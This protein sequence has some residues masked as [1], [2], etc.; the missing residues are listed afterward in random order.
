MNLDLIS[1]GLHSVAAVLWT[2]Y[3]VQGWRF[4]PAARARAARRARA[5][6][7]ARA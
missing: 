3:A 2:A 6:A 4:S 7:R 5:A 1:I